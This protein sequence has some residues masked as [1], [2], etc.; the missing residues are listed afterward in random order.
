MTDADASHANLQNCRKEQLLSISQP[1]RLAR[2][3]STAIPPLG[4]RASSG[5]DACLSPQLMNR[6]EN[7]L[8][9]N[10]GLMGRIC[11]DLTEEVWK[12]STTA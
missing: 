4:A 8:F 9:D 10:K 5:A 2:I 11:A 3:L 1:L 6:M 7:S 12:A